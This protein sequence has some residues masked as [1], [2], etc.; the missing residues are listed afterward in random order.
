[1]ARGGTGSAAGGRVKLLIDM[2]L[3]PE[4]VSLLEG[5]GYEAIHWSSIG[6]FNAPDTEIMQWA[7]DHAGR[8]PQRY[9]GENSERFSGASRR[10]RHQ[11]AQD[12]CWSSRGWSTDYRGRSKIARPHS[13]YLKF[14]SRV[15]RRGM[16]AHT[17][18]FRGGQ[19][20]KFPK[21]ASS[22]VTSVMAPP[23]D[24]VV[25]FQRF[26]RFILASIDPL[27]SEAPYELRP[28]RV[29]SWPPHLHSHSGSGSKL[30]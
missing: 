8:R 5:H 2:N 13:S 26:M 19:T 22:Q 21:P 24:A 12:E 9:P 6:A 10:H 1:M 27:A 17:A 25:P 29:S 7:R 14:T 11:R 30:V 20:R 4:W 16:V 18:S 23:D 3:S 15:G 28:L